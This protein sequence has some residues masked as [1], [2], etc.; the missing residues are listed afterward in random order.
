MGRRDRLVAPVLSGHAAAVHALAFDPTGRRLATGDE[1]G[2]LIIWDVTTGRIL[3]RETVGPSWIWSI[4]F[5]DEG[6][7]L[8]TEVSY[9][10]IVLYDLEGGAAPRRRRAGGDAP[11]R[12]RSHGTT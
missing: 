5:L 3:R 9:G 10:P 7:R 12:G 4:A 11:I 1:S 8:V 2:V 6:R